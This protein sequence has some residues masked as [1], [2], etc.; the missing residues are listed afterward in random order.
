[1]ISDA[2]LDLRIKEAKVAIAAAKILKA[3]AKTA[4]GD[5]SLLR[6]RVDKAGL[7]LITTV[8]NIRDK[9]SQ[10]LVKTEPSL[11]SITNIT[12]SLGSL[13]SR[14]AGT[15]LILPTTDVEPQPEALAIAGE[16]AIRALLG[17][18]PKTPTQRLEA[19]IS[20]LR[21]AERDLA[22]SANAV[23][24]LVNRAAAAS[25]TAG[26]IASCQVQP[27]ASDFKVEPEVSEIELTLPDG[28]YQF[29]ISGGGIPRAA[30]IGSDAA[31]M[32]A[33]SAV[34]GGSHVVKISMDQANLPKARKYVL[35]ISDSSDSASKTID[36]NVL[37]VPS[38]PGDGNGGGDEPSLRPR[39]IT[40]PAPAA[41]PEPADYQARL[42][43]NSIRALQGKLGVIVDGIIGPET[44]GAI[45]AYQKSKG[46]GVT[47]RLT[48]K[49]V[50]DIM[51][52][53]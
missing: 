1:M 37:P 3:D 7:T 34:E 12:N 21:N 20:N 26:D 29:V 24:A 33:I 5:G 52:E 16:V 4:S 47:G 36:V 22:T 8:E 50:T 32:K 35:R 51:A 10:E 49:D 17:T 13:A 18:P 31:G 41:P 15:E 2:E 28:T 27:V 53:N 23:T 14:F 43:Q 6:D 48:E 45:K 46:R 38:E 30:F 40:Q 39:D 11:A 9:V 25:R 19:A 42:D 44:T